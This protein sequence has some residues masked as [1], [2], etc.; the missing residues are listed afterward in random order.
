MKFF[1]VDGE[2]AASHLGKHGQRSISEAG[3]VKIPKHN[4]NSKR[5]IKMRLRYKKVQCTKTSRNGSKYQ[6]DNTTGRVL[7]LYLF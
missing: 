4:S 1:I 5:I 7:A 3:T 2:P 6:S